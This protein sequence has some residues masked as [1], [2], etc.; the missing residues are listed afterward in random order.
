MP[1]MPS[2]SGHQARKGPLQPS[3]LQGV[4][5]QPV[6]WSKTGQKSLG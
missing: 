3:G 6:S 4:S 1:E 5:S 2:A